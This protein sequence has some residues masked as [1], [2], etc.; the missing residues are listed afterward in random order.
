MRYKILVS[1][2][3]I[4]LCKWGVSQNITLKINVQNERNEPVLNATAQILKAADSTILFVK[5]LKDGVFFSLKKNTTYLVRI[6]SVSTTPFFQ[7]FAAGNFDTLLNIKTQTRL[8]NLDEV[9]VTGRKPLVREEDDKT[10]VDAEPLATSST[11]ALEVLEKTPGAI[12]DQDGNVYLN[13]ATPASVYINGR[14]LKMSAQDVASL[15]KGLP[16]SSIAKIEIL[17][18]PSAK[19]DAASS[20]GIVNVVLKKG[21]KLGTNGSL[22]AS[23]FQ[24]V[25]A[26]ETIGFNVN[27]SDK[28]L[29]T[30]LSYNFTNRKNF[31]TLSSVRPTS[32]IIFLQSFFST[33]P[34]VTNYAGGGFDYQA[35]TK[36][37]IAYDVRFTANN[38]RSNI[39]NDIDILNAYG[40]PKAKNVSL[41]NNT[42]PTYFIGNTATAKYKIDSV[43]SE[44]TNSFE[45]TFFNNDNDQLYDNISIYPQKNTLF[46]E[47]NILNRKNI[48]VFKSDI[49]LKTKNKLTIEGGLKVNI[50]R[51]KN[52][53]LYYADSSTGRYINTYQTNS[54]KYKEDIAS[55][56]LQVT[57]TI[58][59]LSVKPGVRLEQTNITGNQIIPTPSAFTIKRTD[60]FPYLFLRHRFRQGNWV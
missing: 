49:V 46:G 3:L 34:T 47:G 24:G 8:K 44:W 10:I 27:K 17:R 43:G 53:A 28:K 50:A 48:A 60:L 12:V 25:Y 45:Y 6:T 40:I 19:Y 23:Y 57:K 20:G 21:V 5:P 14:E 2:L 11:N 1:C 38:N 37:N 42:G 32:Q 52:N 35:R 18:S 41:I 55:V 31:Q 54:F 29:N 59:G 39:R 16:A 56:Y 51:S 58:K 26:T 22:D 7:L 4:L 36:W 30:Y 15:L 33:F 13:S 9:T